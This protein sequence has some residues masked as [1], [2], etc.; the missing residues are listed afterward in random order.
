M[1]TKLKIAIDK[2][3]LKQAHIA[4]TLGWKYRTLGAYVRGE[5]RIPTDKAVEL[6]KILGCRVELVGR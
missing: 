4:K 5:I 6:A 2:S 3:G 1:I